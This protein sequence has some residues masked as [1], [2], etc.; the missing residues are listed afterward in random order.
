M[1]DVDWLACADCVTSIV[2]LATCQWWAPRVR[3]NLTSTPELFSPQKLTALSCTLD[4]ADFWKTSAA[5]SSFCA[6]ARAVSPHGAPC[7]VSVLLCRASGCGD[8]TND[9]N[10]ATT[11][12]LRSAAGVYD[13]TLRR[14]RNL[15]QP[16]ARTSD[17]LFPVVRQESP[18]APSSFLKTYLQVSTRQF[19]DEL[20]VPT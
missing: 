12:Q 3:F 1:S 20:G 6:P 7:G 16:R 15:G 4:V 11:N 19:G 14:Y 10:E 5:T 2:H 13:S 17:L 18:N 8:A 9:A